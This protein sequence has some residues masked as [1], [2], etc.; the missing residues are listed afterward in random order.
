[1]TD[2]SLITQD[3]TDETHILMTLKDMFRKNL[4][5]ER[6]RKLLYDSL[7]SLVH[8]YRASPFKEISCN[9]DSCAWTARGPKTLL[10]HHQKIHADKK[11]IGE[12]EHLALDY[13]LY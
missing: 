2:I 6:S 12:N 10:H 3:P 9:N 4:L 11:D 5:P 13:K 1:M 7:D 8:E